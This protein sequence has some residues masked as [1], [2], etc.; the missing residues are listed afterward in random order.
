MRVANNIKVLVKGGGDL[1]SGAIIRLARAGFP[2]L[3]L[4][5]P[6]PLA[7]RRLVSYAQAVYDGVAHVEETQARLVASGNE[8]WT[9]LSGGDV[10]V[11]VDPEGQT[12]QWFQPDVILDARMT[13]SKAEDLPASGPFLVGLGPGFQA[14]RN[15]HAV[16]ETKRGPFLG[17]VI[18]EGA[19][20]EDT[21]I[22]DWVGPIQ[23]E[24]VI[25]APRDGVF[26]ANTRI[27]DHLVPDQLIGSVEGDALKA[28]FEGVL[29]GLIQDGLWVQKD[30]KIGDLDPRLDPRICRLVSDKALAVG[31][32]VLEAVFIHLARQNKVEE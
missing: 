20:E 30:L 1:A 26:Q 25:R 13:K 24:R 2:I 4:E 32:G 15:C 7:V 16:V 29:R 28:S 23:S 21:G 9:A 5:L 11:M 18:W 10:A 8:A 17:R 22:P 27:G 31:G 3:V 12:A 14:G 19:A 6:Q